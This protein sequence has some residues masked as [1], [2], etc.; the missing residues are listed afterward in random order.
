MPFDNGAGDICPGGGVL[1]QDLAKA[2]QGTRRGGE[3]AVGGSLT[4]ETT[5]RVN[6][7]ADVQEKIT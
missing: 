7:S 5:N 4:E 2:L 3:G 6:V 1:Q